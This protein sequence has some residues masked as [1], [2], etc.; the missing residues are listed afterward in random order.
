MKNVKIARFVLDA[1]VLVHVNRKG[2]ISVTE[3]VRDVN[4]YAR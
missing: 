4:V 2:A 3:N 1:N